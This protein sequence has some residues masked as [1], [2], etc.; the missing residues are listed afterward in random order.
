MSDWAFTLLCAVIHI[1]SFG[2]AQESHE[3]ASG[4]RYERETP[5][6]PHPG[7]VRRGNALARQRRITR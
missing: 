5:P 4:W 3:K 7:A 2:R 1:L 6:R